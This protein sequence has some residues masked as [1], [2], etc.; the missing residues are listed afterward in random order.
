MQNGDVVGLKSVILDLVNCDKRNLAYSVLDHMY[1]RSSTIQDY[2]IVGELS[3]KSEY[4]SLY[5]ECAKTAYNLS[6]TPEQRIAAREN[7]I[8]A[9][10][11]MN[12]PE[13]ALEY[14][15][16]QLKVLP[17]NFEMLCQ[18][19]SNLFLCGD[20]YAS[21]K[22]LDE[23]LIQ[24][25][26]RQR[27]VEFLLSSRYLRQGNTAKGI[28]IFIDTYKKPNDLFHNQLKMKKWSGI[29]Q[30][31]RKIYVASEGGIGD[32]F[33]NI[34][35]FDNIRRMGMEP[36]LYSHDNKFY[37]DKN[38]L[39][40]RHGYV[41]ETDSYA[42]DNNEYWLPMMSLPVVLNLNES[43]LWNDTYLKPLRNEKNRLDG[44]RIKIGIK[45]T[46]NPYFTQ[47]EYRKIPLDLMLSYLPKDV[48][49]YYIDKED[50][51][52]GVIDLADRI[53]SWEDTLDFIDQMDYIVSSCTSLVHAA[54]AMGKTTFVAVPILEYYVWTS[55][56]T[57]NTTPW[58]G[59]NFR[60]MKQTKL[61]DWNEPLSQISSELKKLMKEK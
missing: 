8:K 7:L 10:S 45:C 43:N 28:S 20:K 26:D 9:Y 36:I 56:R 12:Y 33:I 53:D 40:Q 60:V 52:E 49:I 3:L 34:R 17:N 44:D 22:L 37:Q 58:Y 51:H 39:F 11:A 61:R 41:V 46:G 57:D 14:I 2:D 1:E 50:G 31:G 27:D 19:A 13:K 35:F 29:A 24:F 25:P 55:S 4:R 47:D 54:G 59:N 16:Q 38:R 5:F 21:E 48:D 18:K 23:L 15:E 6:L 42:I 32:E 30:P